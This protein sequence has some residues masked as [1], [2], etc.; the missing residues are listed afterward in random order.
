L[1]DAADSSKTAAADVA[2]Q[3][4]VQQGICS[5]WSAMPISEADIPQSGTDCLCAAAGADASDRD[6]NNAISSLNMA[7][8]MAD[9][10][11]AVKKS[12]LRSQA[13]DLPTVAS[14]RSQKANTNR[15]LEPSQDD[16]PT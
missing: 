4:G 10:G 8:Q 7:A 1:V 15:E 12:R 2:M 13:L 11:D 14:P 5:S 9:A 6:K 16:Q 3:S